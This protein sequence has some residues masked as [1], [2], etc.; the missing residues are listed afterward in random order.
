MFT[1]A[2][3]IRC[4]QPL[5]VREARS[6]VEGFAIPKS[7]AYHVYPPDVTMPDAVPSAVTQ[8]YREA[9]QAYRVKLYNACAAMC[10]KTLEGAMV[11]SG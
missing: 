8:P 4:N 9:H 5:L 6:V 3:C 7:D 11:E 10:R 1:F 2:A